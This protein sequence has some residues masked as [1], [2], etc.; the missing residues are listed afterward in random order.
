L[1]TRGNAAI[2][3]FY[4]LN[5]L[6]AGNMMSNNQRNTNRRLFSE[7]L[8]S[9]ALMAGDLVHNFVMPHDVNDDGNVSAI[10]AL[11]IINKLNDDSFD[12]QTI[13]DLSKPDVND[14][15]ILSP[16]DALHVINLINDPSSPR[17]ESNE[18]WLQGTNG[19][20]AQVE[21]EVAGAETELS[22][23]LK[24]AEANKSYPVTLNDVALG[25]LTTDSKGRGR[26]KLSQGDDNRSHLP[27]PASL[28]TLTPDMELTIGQIVSGR[29]GNLSNSTSSGVNSSSDD[30]SS[31]SSSSSI[32]SSTTGPT[33]GGNQQGFSPIALLA[34]FPGTQIKAE[35]EIDER[36]GSMVRKFE[37]EIEDAERNTAYDV[38]IDGKKVATIVTDSRGDGKLKFSSS[39]KDSRET[40]MPLEFPALSEGA[41][42]S[43]GK[44]NTTFRKVV[45]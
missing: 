40:M 12:L 33:T 6:F 27:L 35:Y 23:K 20:R 36:R 18:F 25:E 21:L 1:K 38:L 41:S 8:E 26:I 45:G 13:S 32:S 42:I 30:N 3:S 9:R 17:T 24:S 10:D 2:P 19:A 15:S 44:H 16:L 34:T 29:V 22:I 31:S 4:D 28:T 14:D 39:P 5:P 11:A 7:A 43:V 37:V